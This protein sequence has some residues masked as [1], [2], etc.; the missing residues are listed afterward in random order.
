MWSGILQRSWSTEL[1]H[2]VFPTSHPS[3]VG[4]SVVCSVYS[5]QQNMQANFIYSFSSL[6]FFC[7]ISK[8][9]I[10]KAN[11][12]NWNFNISQVQNFN[13]FKWIVWMKSQRRFLFFFFPFSLVR[14][15]VWHQ[16]RYF[17]ANHWSI[18]LEPWFF[19]LHRHTHIHTFTV[20]CMWF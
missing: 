17:K 3:C 9:H 6:T 8:N 14:I 15:N 18:Q 20:Y 1:L 10:Q 7:P 11:I 4:I 12:F 19:F 2:V 13:G 16:R 5:Q